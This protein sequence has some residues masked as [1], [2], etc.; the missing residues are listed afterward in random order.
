MAWATLA[1][2]LVDL[3]KDFL[4]PLRS[5][6]LG[7]PSWRYSKICVGDHKMAEIFQADIAVAIH[8]FQW[9]SRCAYAVP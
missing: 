8:G 2:A 7:Y 9:S 6:G 4:K 5:S 1:Y 3:I